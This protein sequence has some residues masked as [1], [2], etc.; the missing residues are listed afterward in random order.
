MTSP[1]DTKQGNHHLLA[2]SAELIYKVSHKLLFFKDTNRMSNTCHCLN[3]LIR[4]DGILTHQER[5]Q[6]STSNH[7]TI[8]EKR[9]LNYDLSNDLQ[10]LN[11]YPTWYLSITHII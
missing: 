7:F 5:N 2:S 8:I 4:Q 3:T 9:T 6:E 1:S 10:L 11:G